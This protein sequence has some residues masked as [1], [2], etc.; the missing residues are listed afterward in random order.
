MVSVVNSTNSASW[1]TNGPALLIGRKDAGHAGH[2]GQ[3]ASLAAKCD[4]R[5]SWRWKKSDQVSQQW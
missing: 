1:D 3:R 4:P 5:R 2:A